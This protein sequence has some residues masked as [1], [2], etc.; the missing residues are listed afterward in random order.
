MQNAIF[1]AEW[2]ASYII[3]SAFLCD[4]H[5]HAPH[6]Q[7]STLSFTSRHISH[8]I[9]CY[10]IL[11]NVAWTM[12]CSRLAL[13]GFFFSFYPLYMHIVLYYSYNIWLFFF[14][15]RW[16]FVCARATHLFACLFAPELSRLVFN[17]FC[18]LLSDWENKAVWGKSET[19]N[20][21]KTK[22]WKKLKNNICSAEQKDRMM[23]CMCVPWTSLKIGRE[24]KCNVIKKSVGFAST[25]TYVL[26]DGIEEAFIL[27]QQR[28]KS[29]RAGKEEE[30]KP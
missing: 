4:I 8:L 5:T 22:N 10:F 20:W 12:R 17:L 6:H 18:H 13:D 9:F 14:H 28:K 21:K 24:I 27:Y 16:C 26:D 1:T 15:S 7:T 25:W 29:K 19:E 11:I 2:R 3:L 30:W 23:H